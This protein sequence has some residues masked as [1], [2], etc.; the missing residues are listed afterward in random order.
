MQEVIL[1]K[2]GEMVLKGLNRSSFEKKLLSNVTHSL[3]GCGNFK[4][5][6][7][8]ST[9]Y[10][11]PDGPADIDEAFRRAAGI[12]GLATITRAAACE[13]DLSKI[14]QTA[15]EYLKDTLS[16]ASTFKVEARRADKTFPLTS[17]EICREVGG[18]LSDA[19]THL[20]VKVDKPEVL[21]MVE[22]R[23]LL[24]YVHTQALPGAG[25]MPAGMG[26]RAALLLSG[27]ID[28][29]VAGYMMA[30]RGLALEAVHFFSYPYTSERAKRKVFDL[31]EI[32]SGFC[33]HI[34]VHV[35]PFTHIQEE[36]R[37]NCPEDL[38]TI[39]M[40][41][42]MMRIAQAVAERTGCGALIT[43]ESLGQVA[44]QTME[45]MSVTG[46]VCTLPVLRPVVGMDKEEIV[47]IARRIG[48]FETSIQ[49][50]ED[51]CTVFTPK[52]PRTKPRLADVVAAE[53]KLDIEALVREAVDGVERVGF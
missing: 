47:L 24:A 45:A 17:P 12:F 43:G 39:I 15:I 1:L 23:D 2:Q 38:F 36:I 13:K 37:A 33:G 42:F 48:T 49:P 44:S 8:Q 27:G 46:Q 26:G 50:Y 51:C 14:I 20:K 28:S 7:M 3:K 31:A 11:E 6:A 4:V 29:P 34:T 16:G 5:Y 22:V 19:F 40:R 10:V 18:A 30:K 35:V 21:V 41:L 32:L 52:H 9:I 25:G 53:E